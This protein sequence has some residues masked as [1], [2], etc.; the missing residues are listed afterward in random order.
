MDYARR[1]ALNR[2]LGRMGEQFSLDIERRRL[3]QAQRDDLAARVEWVAE[4]CGD[5]VGF[6]ILSFD[7]RDD[8]ELCLE[9]KTT[10]LGRYFPFL[11]TENE[12]RCSED[13]GERFQ[14]YRV[15]DFSRR[16]RV[17]VLPGSLLVTCHL[18][19]TLYR[20]RVVGE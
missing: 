18:E 11:V 13:L 16:P 15:F 3:L 20:A 9:V 8:S 2:Q 6:D 10:C 4:T 12:R 19:P 1:D 5:G 17:Y 14:L 7:E